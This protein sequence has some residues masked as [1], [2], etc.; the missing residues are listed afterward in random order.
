MSKTFHGGARGADA[1]L[2]ELVDQQ[3]P[4]RTD[5]VGTTFSQLL[6]Q[7]RAALVVVP[8]APPLRLALLADRSV[9]TD[10][11]ISRRTV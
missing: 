10:Q 8:S 7:L 9:R 4:S 3:A 6:D 2:R 1:A 5:G 11:L